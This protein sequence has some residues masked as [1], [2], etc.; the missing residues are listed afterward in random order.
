ML[1]LR[2]ARGGYGSSEATRDVV[3]AL[4]ALEAK[5]ARPARVVVFDG[6]AKRVVDVAAN[7]SATLS[8]GPRTTELLLDVQG[9]AVFARLERPALRP[10][11]T[12]P[13]ASVAP[14]AVSVDWPNDAKAGST[15]VVHLAY[16]T[17]L[18]R[19]TGVW[20][21]MPLPPGVELAAPVR[22]VALRQGVLHVRTNVGVEETIPLPV[23]FTL[24][25]KVLVPEAET[26]VVSEE[27]PRTLTPARALAIR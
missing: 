10:Y 9:G 14:V 20:T 24:P 21:R 23:R 22:N 2:D 11:G 5:L 8:L 15:G 25:G 17:S 7:G 12:A 26:R 13:D 27:H 16:R 1:A 6:G 19:N 4:T 18:G 3:R